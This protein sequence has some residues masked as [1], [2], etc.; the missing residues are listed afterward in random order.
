[1]KKFLNLPDAIFLWP[2]TGTASKRFADSRQILSLPI[3]EPALD[4]LIKGEPIRMTIDRIIMAVVG[5]IAGFCMV[6]FIWG[7]WS[8][9]YYEKFKNNSDLDVVLLVGYPQYP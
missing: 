6:M 4:K 5:C 3:R 2:T 7:G 9:K 8:E 1:M